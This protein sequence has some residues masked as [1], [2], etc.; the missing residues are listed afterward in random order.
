MSD[1]PE[2]ESLDQRYKTKVNPDQIERRKDTLRNLPVLPDLSTA[3]GPD[4]ERQ[5]TA[6]TAIEDPSI[7]HPSFKDLIL[8]NPTLKLYSTGEGGNLIMTSQI[9]ERLSAIIFSFFKA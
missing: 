3:L 7:I 2:F 9:N 5:Y 1:V 8:E 6:R 4:L